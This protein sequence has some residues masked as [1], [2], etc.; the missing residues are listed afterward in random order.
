MEKYDKRK[1]LASRDIIARAIDNEMKTNG[2]TNVYLD[3]SHKPSEFIRKRFPRI[4][5]KCLSVNIDITKERI[6]VI[7]ASHY[8]CGGVK[9]DVSGKTEIDYLYVIGESAHTGFHGANRLASNSLLE[10]LV[11]S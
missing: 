5:E 8:T 2:Y 9:T 11:M 10:C 6:P 1:E 7:P 4:Y 3:I